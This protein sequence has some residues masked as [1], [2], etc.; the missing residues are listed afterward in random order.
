MVVKITLFSILI[1]V[2]VIALSREAIQNKFTFYPDR[3]SEIPEQNI[4]SFI[5]ERQINT[6]DGETLQAFLFRHEENVQ[7]P[8]IIYFHGNAGNLY[9][10]FE[11]AKRLFEMEHDVL[12]VSYRGYSKSTGKPSE[13]GIFIDGESAVKYAI[14]ELGMDENDITIFGRSLGTT[15]AT[16]I[17]QNRNF[18]GVILVTPL[19]SGKDMATAMGLGLIK[20]MAGNSFNSIDKINNIKTK[21]LIIHGDE[22]ELIPYAMGKQLMEKFTGTKRM[23]TIKGGSH[24]DLQEVNS[25]LYW[26]EIQKFLL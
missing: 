15:V 8:L 26:G 23:V 11:P 18:R 6:L 7:R 9:S 2:V 3:I 25:M 21:I 10:R 16:H 17:A 19:T 22:D 1:V 12:L 24:N 14:N 20:F 13:N 5:S 4:P